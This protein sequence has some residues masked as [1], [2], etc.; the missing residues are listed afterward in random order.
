[1]PI[2]FHVLPAEW[3]ICYAPK[4][5]SGSDKPYELGENEVAAVFLGEAQ[6]G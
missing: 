1:M 2:N 4:E 6:T 5:V 3:P